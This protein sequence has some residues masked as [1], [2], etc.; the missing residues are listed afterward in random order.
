MQCYTIW[1]L[2]RVPLPEEG[3]ALIQQQVE[4]PQLVAAPEGN[5]HNAQLAFA[6][7]RQITET[8]F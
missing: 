1:L 5:P 3:E 4:Q 7:R 6:L 2:T 8:C